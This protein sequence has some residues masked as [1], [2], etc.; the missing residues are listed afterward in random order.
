[1]VTAK[2]LD[3]DSKGRIRVVEPVSTTTNITI[4]QIVIPR[5]VILFNTFVKFSCRWVKPK[6]LQYTSSKTRCEKRPCGT[7]RSAA[8]VM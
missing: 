1:M 4:Q 7:E 8:A 5:K 2:I 3:E 6:T